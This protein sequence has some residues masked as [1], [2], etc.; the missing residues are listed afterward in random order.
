MTRRAR[1]YWYGSAVALMIGGSVVDLLFGGI[2]GEAI[3]IA[4]ASLGLIELIS[5]VYY[6]VGLSEDRER[7]G[8]AARAR[9]AAPSRTR[10]RRIP[11]RPRRPT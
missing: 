3:G 5:L 2:T 7:A 4:L 1:L 10:P 6:E 9:P 8:A 11:R